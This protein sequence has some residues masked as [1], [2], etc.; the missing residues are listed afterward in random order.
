MYTQ[1]VGLSPSIIIEIIE[2]YKITLDV[3]YNWQASVLGEVREKNC[4]LFSVRVW[5]ESTREL[6]NALI[7]WNSLAGK[8]LKERWE[9]SE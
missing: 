4:W 2:K 9:M 1:T 8:G 6:S 3:I 5:I 7:I